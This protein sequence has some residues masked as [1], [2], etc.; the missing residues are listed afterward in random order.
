[1][2]ARVCVMI[3]GVK[4]LEGGVRREELSAGTLRGS[5]GSLG[6]SLGMSAS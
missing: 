2:R 5:S 6:K 1:M 3:R 4:C